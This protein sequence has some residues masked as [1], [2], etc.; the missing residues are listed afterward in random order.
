MV[1]GRNLSATY[2]IDVNERRRVG[3]FGGTF[4]P[5]HVAHIVLAAAAIDQLGL[6][7]LII[8]VA[9]VP[10]QKVGSR[11]ISPAT[12]RLEMVEAAFSDVQ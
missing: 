4:D 11:P 10:W 2:R 3:L 1:S 6:D 5:P 12:T 7:V 9:G 8:T